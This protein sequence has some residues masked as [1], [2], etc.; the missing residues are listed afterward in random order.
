MGPPNIR[1]T[2]S[3]LCLA[4]LFRLTS[5]SLCLA[6]LFRLTSPSLCLADLFR[7]TRPEESSGCPGS[8][9]HA[10]AALIQCE[11]VLDDKPCPQPSMR[12]CVSADEHPEEPQSYQEQLQQQL[13]QQQQ[14]QEQE[15][16]PTMASVP[17]TAATTEEATTMETVIALL[18][19]HN[20][21]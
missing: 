2:S 9:Y 8:C 19:I 11:K 15:Q 20:H 5:P 1:L 14:E 4:D 16:M 12:C 13:E 7:L 18:G 6:D 21:Y 10:L 17:E 3:S